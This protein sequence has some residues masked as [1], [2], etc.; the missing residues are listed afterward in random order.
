MTLTQ[1]EFTKDRPDKSPLG[2][3]VPV[4]LRSGAG[5]PVR[6]LLQKSATVTVP[7]CDPVVVNAGQ[8]GYYR[9]HYTPAQ[10]GRLAGGFG[11]L[12]PID[13]LG[14][15]SDSWALGRAG[16]QPISDVLD[17]ARA[18][19]VDADPQVWGQLAQILGGLDS[20][21][22]ADRARGDAFRRFALARL[23]P[24][25]ARVGWTARRGGAGA[26]RGPAQRA[27]RDA[28]RPGRSGRDRR[29]PPPVPRG[30]DGP[31]GD[32]GCRCARRS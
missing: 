27:D 17:L 22:R 8:S 1:G 23:Q 13:Q 4:I 5:E 20:Y 32:A 25:F 6:T 28:G 24:V 14:V 31:G 15:L 9:T 7:G 12:P 18:T 2:W 30:G 29:G 19:P 3:R 16:V 11:A 26:A 21:A 10:F